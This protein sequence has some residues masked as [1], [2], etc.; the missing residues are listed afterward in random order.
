MYQDL[1]TSCQADV[2]LQEI[3]TGNIPFREMKDPTVILEVAHNRRTPKVPELQTEPVSP[4]ASIMFGILHWC[5]Q[6]D[7]SE[8]AKAHEIAGLVSPLHLK[9]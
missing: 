8:R 1:D 9:T 2:V 7:P 5:W 3:L 4:R 6:H